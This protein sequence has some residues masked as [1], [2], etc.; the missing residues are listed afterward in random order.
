MEISSSF[1][2]FEDFVG[3]LSRWL[4]LMGLIPFFLMLAL[5]F[6]DVVG[7]K[8]FSIPVPGAPEIIS[9]MQ[10]L[11]AS[12]AIAFLQFS[13]GHTQI[14]FFVSKLGKPQQALVNCVISFL[15]LIL[16]ALLSWESFMHGRSL[17][18]AGEIS[19]TA[20]WP[21]YPFAYFLSF[22]CLLVCLVA[23]SQYLRWFIRGRSD[24]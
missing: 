11:A 10:V 20:R 19:S 7:A 21:L 17:Q 1:N 4:A 5:T 16:F 18:V 13:E 3:R 12:S 15:L 2:R 6:I 23:L 14:D 9:L 22:G 24:K 8:I